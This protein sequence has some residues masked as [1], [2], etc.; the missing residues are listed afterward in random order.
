MKHAGSDAPDS[1]EELLVVLR[2]RSVLRERKRG[3]FYLK[4]K[5]RS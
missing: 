1:I 5:M 2:E 3:I 4:S